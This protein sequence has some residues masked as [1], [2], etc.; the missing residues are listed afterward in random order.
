MGEIRIAA[1]E[2][3]KGTRP[4]TERR[5]EEGGVNDNLY[6]LVR[7][8]KMWKKGKIMRSLLEG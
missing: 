8:E 4:K 5:I 1:R 2:C 3:K 6:D 7:S